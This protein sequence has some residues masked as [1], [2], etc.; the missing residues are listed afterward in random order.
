MGIKKST[1]KLEKPG[2][3]GA[4]AGAK[5]EAGP[6]TLQVESQP[7][8]RSENMEESSHYVYHQDPEHSKPGGNY[9][10]S[11]TVQSASTDI[12]MEEKTLTC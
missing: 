2:N 9:Q 3:A 7:I 10:Y 6:N 5:T 1:E 4:N 12:R 11:P 8:A